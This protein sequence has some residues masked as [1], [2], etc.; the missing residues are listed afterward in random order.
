MY[1]K[2]TTHPHPVTHRRAVVV[3]D[4]GAEWNMRKY[5]AMNNAKKWLRSIT[6]NNQVTE[7]ASPFKRKE[8]Q[9]TV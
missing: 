2:F 7:Y 3:T 8:Q 4:G 1:L 5:N 9:G 6:R